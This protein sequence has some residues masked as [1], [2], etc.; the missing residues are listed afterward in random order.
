MASKFF[1][2]IELTKTGQNSLTKTSTHQE[3]K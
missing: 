1:H 3:Q 2:R